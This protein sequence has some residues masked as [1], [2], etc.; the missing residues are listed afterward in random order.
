MFVGAVWGNVLLSL[1][2]LRAIMYFNIAL[3]ALGA[4]LVAVLAS[5]DGAVG[6]AIGTATTESI[7]CP[8]RPGSSWFVPTLD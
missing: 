1:Q 2:R 3:L 4:V 6:A 7:G 8:H 5:L